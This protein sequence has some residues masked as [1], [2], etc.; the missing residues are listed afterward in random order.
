MPSPSA[1]HFVRATVSDV[2]RVRAIVRAAYQRW[3]PVIGREPLPMTV[4]YDRVVVDHHI[5]LLVVSGDVVGLIEMMPRDDHLWIE[6]VAVS[7]DRQ[8]NG[9]G[10]SLLDHAEALAR[11]AGKPEV[12]LLTNAAFAD[13][14]ALYRRFG[15]AVSRIEPFRGGKTVYMAKAVPDESGPVSTP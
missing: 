7:P 12:R 8:G 2:D 9:Y 14:V 5:D 15:Y 11:A 1:P 4:D 3:V 6:N 10:R 13:N